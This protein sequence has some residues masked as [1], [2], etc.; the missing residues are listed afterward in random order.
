MSVMDRKYWN[1]LGNVF[2][3]VLFVF[4]IATM[5]LMSM[6]AQG[7][8]KQFGYIIT[9]GAFGFMIVSTALRY[10]KGWFSKALRTA[11]FCL[12]ASWYSIGGYVFTFMGKPDV[13][14]AMLWTDV[15]LV[16]CI[17]AIASMMD[18]IPSFMRD[19]E[20]TQMPVS[21]PA[22]IYNNGHDVEYAE[23]DINKSFQDK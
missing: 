18:D 7:E 6:K 4:N 8:Y 20:H 5:I 16:L 23:Y 19:N 21:K 12:F 2:T 17:A 1:K 10:I 13:V 3:F 9:G 22:I 15:G 14:M 11:T